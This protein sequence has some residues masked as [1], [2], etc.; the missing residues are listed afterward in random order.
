[1][2]YTGSDADEG[3]RQFADKLAGALP[4]ST[5]VGWKSDRPTAVQSVQQLG[6]N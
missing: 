1:M 6:G 3:L 2:S 4:K 5:C